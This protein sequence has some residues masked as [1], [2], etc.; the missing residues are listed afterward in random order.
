MPQRRNNEYGYYLLVNPVN[1]PVFLVYPSRPIARKVMFQGFRLS[2]T[3]LR[4]LPEF[5]KYLFYFLN[6]GSVAGF[7]KCL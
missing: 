4:M 1:Q 3:G 2:N 5:I 7:I 6:T